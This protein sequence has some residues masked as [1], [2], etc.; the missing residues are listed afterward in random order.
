MSENTEVLTAA[1]L[2]DRK[3][4]GPWLGAEF[5]V[6]YGSTLLITGCFDWAQKLGASAGTRLWITAAWGFAYIFVSFLGGRVAEKLG[7]RRAGATMCAACVGT[8]LL[9]L[10]ALLPS[11]QTI[12]MIP[13]VML[14]FNVT[15]TMIW[16]ALESGLTRSPGA[17]GLSRRTAFYNLSWGAAGFL[18]TFT[19]GVV[20]S[21][22][23]ATVFVVAAVSCGMAAL[24]LS[25]WAVPAS[26]IGAHQVPEE[27]A[28]EQELVDPAA[29][30]RAGVLLKMAWVANPLSYMAVY[31][32]MP[33][34]TQLCERAQIVDWR[35]AAMV[36]SIWF[37][38]RFLGFAVLG[39]WK[40]WHYKVRWLMGPLVALG[41]SL[42]A[43]LLV[44]NA[45]VLV[46]GQVVFGFSTAVVYSASL[47]YAM[48][49]SSGHGGH[50]AFHE[51]MI[52]VGTVV[53]PVIGALASMG[54][55]G[56][57]EVAMPRIALAVTGVLVAGILAVGWMGRGGAE[58]R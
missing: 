19:H 45:W 16:P 58:T 49:V 37:V 8:A 27:E 22:S 5:L 43:M 57:G 55:G 10:V 52:G 3:T 44:P 26:M 6:S 40:G 18:G 56:G 21:T 46:G 28:G 33:V 15:C 17:M 42:A 53:G 32:L 36:G 47:Y 9:G 38:V 2:T 23:F 14:P 54:E 13:L 11:L 12:W 31:V 41:A 51:A 35:W 34:M 24:V 7:P 50:A 25:V 29:R 48:H 39:R 20:E 1:R 30:R 4:L